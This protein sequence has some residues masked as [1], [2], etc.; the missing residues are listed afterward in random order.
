MAARRTLPLLVALWVTLVHGQNY[1]PVN[2]TTTIL[3]DGGGTAEVRAYPVYVDPATPYVMAGSGGSL[4][5]FDT[6]GN[7][8]SS[9]AGQFDV[10]AVANGVDFGGQGG[11]LVATG[12]FET[13][14]CG[15]QRCLR[16]FRWDPVGGFQNL[17]FT[18]T[19]VN[20]MAAMTLDATNAPTFAIYYASVG[21]S[22]FQP[23]YRQDISIGA[24][25]GIT[26]L[27]TNQTNRTLPINTLFGMAAFAGST[28]FV[29]SDNGPLDAFPTDLTNLDGGVFFPLGSIGELDGIS[30]VPIDGGQ[31]IIAGDK[32]KNAVMF[33]DTQ[34]AVFQG[35]LSIVAPLND[36]GHRTVVP[37]G[38]AATPG[39]ALLVVTEPATPGVPE[40]ASNAAVYLAPFTF[41]DAGGGGGGPDGGGGGGGIP[42]I[43]SIPPGP[44]AVPPNSYGCSSASGVPLLVTF[45]IPLL[46][47]RRRRR[48]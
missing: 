6:N 45:L 11:T 32:T 37:H 20:V 29:T 22:G 7:Q 40:I 36:G 17:D 2:V 1:Q 21:P 30:L 38:A 34:S 27:A 8:V 48:R 12:S 10:F 9:L 23:V 47:P 25:G 15:G 44:G 19:T 3:L 14:T 46:L 41:P 33:I 31:S 35:G 16:V 28:L 4:Q 13:G 42:T 43:P 26:F 18:N 5:V 24:D 39:P